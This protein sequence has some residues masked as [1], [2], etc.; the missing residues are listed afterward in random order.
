M[1]VYIKLDGSTGIDADNFSFSS[2]IDYNFILQTGIS[3]AILVSTGYTLTNVQ[4]GATIIRIKSNTTSCT[5]TIDFN[6]G[7]L[8]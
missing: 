8:P 2:D 5:N 7:G 3:R 1:N 4:D 6:I